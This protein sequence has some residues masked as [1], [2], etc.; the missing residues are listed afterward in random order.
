ML[1]GEFWHEGEFCILFGQANTGKS[2][3]TT[4]IVLGLSKGES[5]HEYFAVESSPRKFYF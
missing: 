2:T 1:F 5:E 4:Q 3:L